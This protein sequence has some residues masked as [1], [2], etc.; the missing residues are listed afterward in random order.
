MKMKKSPVTSKQLATMFPKF[1]RKPS[2]AANVCDTLE[3]HG[4][5]AKVYDNCWQ[6]TPFGV[7]ACYTLGK[8][9]S[10]NVIN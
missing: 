8:R 9:D 2:D 1:Y 4:L 3:K 10:I 7:K 5:I 6:I